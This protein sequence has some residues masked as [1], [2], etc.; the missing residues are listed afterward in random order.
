VSFISCQIDVPRCELGVR[1][2]AGHEPLAD[3]VA[4]NGAL[5]AGG[6]RDQEPRG[7]RQREGGRME[8]HEL[9]VLDRGARPKSG[10][11]SVAGGDGR[12]RGDAE[13]LTD[14]AGGDDRGPRLDQDIAAPRQVGGAR[15]GARAVVAQQQIAHEQPLVQADA[16][17]LPGLL[18]E[19][20][21][22]LAPGR[23][24]VGVEDA[25]APMRRLASQREPIPGH[26]EL[27][28][29]VHELL[30]QPRPLARQDLHRGF[31]AQA[32]ASDQRIREMLLRGILGV[33]GDG[34]PALR[35]EGAAL[36]QVV[37]GDQRHRALLGE[38][39]RGPQAG[40]PAP[41]HQEVGAHR[42]QVTRVDQLQI[43]HVAVGAVAAA[44]RT[45]FMLPDRKPWRSS[46]T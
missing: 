44:L 24:A 38:A 4:Q 22:H 21:L 7:I 18:G 2:V 25:V 35:V 43:A 32:R 36:D 11:D 5:A 37:L 33:Q 14:A 13:D 42:L 9:Q 10:G 39:D 23:V 28:A 20:R 29:H 46:V 12:I 30:D 26:V 6:L 16:F 45:S 40:N 41:H 17:H 1:V 31:V 34:D 8:L 27:R 15:P 19:A 3:V